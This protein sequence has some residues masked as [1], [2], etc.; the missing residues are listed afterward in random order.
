MQPREKLWHKTQQK[1]T[2]ESNVTQNTTHWNFIKWE[3][4]LLCTVPPAHAPASVSDLKIQSFFEIRNHLT[5]PM[6]YSTYWKTISRHNQLWFV[7]V[8]I[9]TRCDFFSWRNCRLP[10]PTQFNSSVRPSVILSIISLFNYSAEKGLGPSES[11]NK[12]TKIVNR[13]GIVSQIFFKMN[14]Y[15]MILAK[16]RAICILY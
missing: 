13:R 16:I 7:G 3:K 5:I 1:M 11:V 2:K 6:W 9:M 10:S 14:L 8:L 15:I 12:Y 4:K